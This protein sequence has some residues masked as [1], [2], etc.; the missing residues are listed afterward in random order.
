MTRRGAGTTRTA[1]TAL[2][3]LSLAVPGAAWAQRQT[4]HPDHARQAAI[5]I[6]ASMRAE[7]AE[8]HAELVRATRASGRVGTAARALQAVLDPHFERE[9]QVA[10]PPLGLL[11][12]LARGEMTPAMREVLPMTDSLRA[13]MPKML[14]EH[15]AIRTATERLARAAR[16]ARDTAVVQLAE[17]LR[18]HAQSEEEMF[19]PAAMLVGDLV[20]ARLATP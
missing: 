17:K 2:A 19:Y 14:E 16:A 11:A 20:R 9:E 3:A 10:L 5:E 18:L 1:A 4:A 8:L 15:A 7:H 13:E 12:P 6:P